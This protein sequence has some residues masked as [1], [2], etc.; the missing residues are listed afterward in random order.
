MRRRNQPTI[1][2]D[3]H[4][5]IIYSEFILCAFI[6]SVITVRCLTLAWAVG[7][8]LF[9][10]Y[11][12]ALDWLFFNVFIWR[13]LFSTMM[14]VGFGYFAFQMTGILNSINKN[15]WIMA[16][17]S[18]IFVLWVHR[19]EYKFESTASI[20]IFDYIGKD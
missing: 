6:L 2:V 7:V 10:P 8:I 16:I 11:I 13:W 12:L 15:A 17:A 5:G 1:F 4:G 14:S 9:I 20:S 19:N 18:F 3:R